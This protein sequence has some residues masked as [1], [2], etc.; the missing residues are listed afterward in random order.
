MENSHLPLIHSRTNDASFYQKWR[1]Q[2]AACGGE[3]ALCQPLTDVA[4]DRR[5]FT[6]VHLCADAGQPG[7]GH[8]SANMFCT[9]LAHR[10]LAQVALHLHMC[11]AHIALHMH[12][13]TNSSA[14]TALHT[15]PCTHTLHMHPCTRTLQCTPAHAPLHTHPAHTPCIR[16]PAHALLHTHT[17]TPARTPCICTPA[18]TPCT[19]TPAYTAPSALL[20]LASF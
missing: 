20:S 11:P 12:H 19:R 16:T 17:C 9:C 14:Y 3:V 15:H 4:L 2:P 18:H 7:A 6:E 10:F 8:H 1:N 13:C 5:M